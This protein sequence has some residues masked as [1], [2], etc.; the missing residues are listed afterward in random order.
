[1]DLYVY[2]TKQRKKR[3]FEPLDND[4]VRIYVCGP[5]VYDR[6]HIG[7]GLSAVVFDVFVRVLRAVFQRV[8]YVRNVTDVDDKINRRAQELGVPIEELTRDCTAAM[9]EDFSA[10]GVLPPDVEPKATEH[11]EPIISMI[12]SLIQ[13]GFAYHANDH[14]LFYVPSDP[15]YGSLT[16]KSLEDLIDGARVEV[17]PYKR[18]P[19]DFVLWKPSTPELPGWDSPWGR[20]RPGWHIE[21]S[22]MIREHLGNVIDIHGGGTDLAFPHH[23]NEMAQSGCFH[24]DPDYVRY[25][26]HN[27]MLNLGAEKMSKSL[28]NIQTIHELLQTHEGETLRYAILT[29]HYRQS[30]RW[31]D[32][33]IS[34]SD[35]T[36][37]SLYQALRNA[38]AIAG[39][40]PTSEAFAQRSAEDIPIEVL[41]PLCDD[42]N[43]PRALAAMHDLASQLNV[44]KDAATANELRSKLLAGGW[45]LGLLTRNVSEFFTQDAALEEHE[46]ERLIQE[47]TEAKALKN[48]GRA[49]EIRETL[50]EAGI[51]IEDTRNGTNWKVVK[52]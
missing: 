20:G 35:R 18:D 21:C 42:L 19:K 38:E 33:L 26:M 37:T 36:L 10:L 14:V 28:G 9:H 52:N 46:I 6:V 48:Y 2:D 1:M 47:R 12:S 24:D 34:Q 40:A 16:N 43:T 15:N 8:T 50:L 27:G 23:E 51:A 45:L 44:C 41:T 4:H 39:V 30:L 29:G 5:T 22:A 13:Q 11:I 7:N 17:A 49:D 31:D 32:E 25:W 3:R